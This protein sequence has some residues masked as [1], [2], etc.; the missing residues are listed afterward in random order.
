MK[1]VIG[2][3]YHTTWQA[4]KAMRFVLS[5][6]NGDKVRL[7]TRT[8]GKSFW[9]DKSSLIEIDSKHNR[10]KKKRLLASKSTFA[11]VEDL[12]PE[13]TAEIVSMLT[14]KNIPY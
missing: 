3:N 6:I 11:Q 13:K 9:T 5:E 4:H 1:L 8:T 2:C 14:D 7:S 12:N 10:N